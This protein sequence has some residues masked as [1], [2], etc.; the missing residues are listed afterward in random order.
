MVVEKILAAGEELPGSWAGRRDDRLRLPEPR[1]ASC[2]STRRARPRCGT[3]YARFTGV[4]GGLRRASRY[5][6]KLQIMRED[7]AAE[8]ERLTELLAGSASGTG[9]S[10]TTPGGSCAR[11]SPS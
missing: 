3:C 2:S 4:T 6:A 8:V 9:A 1:S 7:L 10:A 5:A 11:R